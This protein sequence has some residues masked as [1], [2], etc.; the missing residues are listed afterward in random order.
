MEVT[1]ISLRRDDDTGRCT[2][3]VY[4]P[5]SPRALV[6]IDD[7]GEWINHTVNFGRREGWW[8]RV[9]HWITGRW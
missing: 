1:G 5:E 9:R 8:E 6:V 3:A 2:V 7:A 4:S